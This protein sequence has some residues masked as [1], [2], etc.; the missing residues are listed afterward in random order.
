MLGER[1]RFDW[2]YFFF[3]FNSSKVILLWWYVDFV[4]RCLFMLKNLNYNYF[5]Y[6]IYLVKYVMVVNVIE[7]ELN[8]CRWVNIMWLIV[9]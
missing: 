9:I 7:N 6:L 1:N 5:S 8:G 3:K 2:S 4:C